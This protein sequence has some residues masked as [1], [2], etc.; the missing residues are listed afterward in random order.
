LS[1]ARF[2]E[3]HDDFHAA[4]RLHEFASNLPWSDEDRHRWHRSMKRELKA[5]H[6]ESIEAAIRVIE[7]REELNF[8]SE[9]AFWGSRR[10]HMRYEQTRRAGRP[11]GSG[12]VESAVRRV[13]NLRMKGASI[14]WT[15]EHAEGSFTYAHTRRADAG[16]SWRGRFSRTALGG[17]PAVSLGRQREPVHRCRL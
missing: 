6:I 17:R 1:S 2:F 7:R 10:K 3:V 9:R 13:V 14:V 4:E 11:L 8:S 12:A 15:E 5:G 16:P